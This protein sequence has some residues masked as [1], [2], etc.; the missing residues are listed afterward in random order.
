MLRLPG[1]DPL[2]WEFP[3]PASALDDPDGLLA[4]GGDLSPGRLISAYSSG[5]FPWFNDDQPILWWSP[6]TRAILDTADLRVTRSLRKSLRNRGFRVSADRC[7]DTVIHACAA[8]RAKAGGTWIVGDMQQAYSVLHALGLAHSVEVWLEDRL[9]GGLYGISFKGC[10]FGESMFSRVSD[11]S[12]VAFVTL[13]DFLR[14]NDITLIDCQMMTPH[15]Q[16]LGARPMSRDDYLCLLRDT[17]ARHPGPFLP[18]RWTL[19]SDLPPVP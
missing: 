1:L 13:V 3:D 9:V 6:S 5:I 4:V 12:K 18:G 19:D 8:P 14:R 15:L 16:S 7:F 11:A 2:D 17:L 10:Y